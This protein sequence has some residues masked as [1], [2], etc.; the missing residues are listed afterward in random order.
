LVISKIRKP[1]AFRGE[2]AIQAETRVEK[3][4]NFGPASIQS[5]RIETEEKVESS[6]SLET[7]SGAERNKLR[8]GYLL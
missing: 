8:R 2:T 6:L 1:Q 7:G 5:T 3:W 4:I